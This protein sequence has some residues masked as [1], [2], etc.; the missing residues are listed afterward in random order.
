MVGA[1]VGDQVVR[2]VLE[3]GPFSDATEDALLGDLS[4]VGFVS[5]LGEDGGRGA[6]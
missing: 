2:Q 5:R 4:A 1:R 6:G 3:E